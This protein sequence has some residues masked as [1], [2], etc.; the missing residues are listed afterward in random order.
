MISKCEWHDYAGYL[1]LD[2]LPM[3]LINREGQVEWRAELDPW[4]NVLSEDN[5]HNI[6]QPLRLPGQ[7]YDGE[8]GLHY[9]WYYDP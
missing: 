6:E 9:N 7:W 5:P 3:A 1:Q 4:G 2:P 8:S